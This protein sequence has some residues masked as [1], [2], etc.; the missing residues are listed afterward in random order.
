VRAAAR[1]F[2]DVTA[3]DE[4][5]PVIQRLH[6]ALSAYVSFVADNE[7]IYV[8]F[9][10]GTAGGDGELQEIFDDV[11]ATIVDR[12]S[13]ALGGV[14]SSPTVRN[15]LRGWVGFVEESTIDWLRH[16]DIEQEKLVQLHEL[17]LFRS[18]EVAARS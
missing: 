4:N 7:A 18:L 15:A 5:L 3:P 16:R 14:E 12:V 10:R 9:L 6:A 13:D 8:S 17:M 1:L 11:R 2:L